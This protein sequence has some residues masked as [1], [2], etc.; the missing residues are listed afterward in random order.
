MR[1]FSG[2]EKLAYSIEVHEYVRDHGNR[3][4]HSFIGCPPSLFFHISQVLHAGK[5]YRA[6]Q[7]SVDAFQ[8]VL[9]KAANFFFFWDPEQE[10]Y[11]TAAPEWALLAEAFRHA[12]I[13]RVLRFPDPFATACTDPAVQTSAAAIL[14][15]CARMSRNGSSVYFKRLL[16]PLF[17]AGAETASP[18]QV[19][20]VNMCID[21]IKLATG[22]QY[23]AMTEMLEQVWDERRKSD[24]DKA[25]VPWMEFVSV[26]LCCRFMGANAN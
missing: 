5:I 4:F 19:H 24:N 9:D 15:I 6:K 12:C 2:A 20:Y 25:N 23:P 22:F 13:L 26:E 10:T 11:P 14:D 17:L 16:F 1:G 18:H 8:V 7:L 21:E 3:I